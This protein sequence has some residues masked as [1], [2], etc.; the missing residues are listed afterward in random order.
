MKSE[1]KFGIRSSE[2]G[3]ER[4]VKDMRIGRTQHSL[5]LA[6]GGGREALGGDCCRWAVRS[7]E[8]CKNVPYTVGTDALVGP[9]PGGPGNSEFGIRSSEF[10]EKRTVQ[11]VG[12]TLVVAR[13]G[14]VLISESLRRIRRETDILSLCL[15]K[16]KEAKRNDTREGKI[17]IPSPPETHPNGNAQEGRS[18][19]GSPPGGTDSSGA[20]AFFRFLRRA[21]TSPAPTTGRKRVHVRGPPRVSAPTV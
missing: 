20:S 17:A 14:T 7:S 21:G 2:F 19:L 13:R 18:P 15:S 8:L 11:T 6:R 1:E 12:A 3:V 10:I 16:E 9:L 5:P 4:I